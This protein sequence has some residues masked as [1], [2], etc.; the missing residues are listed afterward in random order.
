MNVKHAIA[1][2]SCTAALHL[3]NVACGVG[4]DD[5]VICPDL[6]FVASA[7]ASRYTGAKVVFAGVRS[8]EDL[9]IDPADIEAHITPRTKAVTVVHYAGFAC[10]MKEIL[11]VT[12]RYNLKVIEDCAHAPFAWESASGGSRR[13][14]GSIGDVG[15]FSFF[16]NK[17]M[18]TGEGGMVTTNDDDIAAKVKLLRS[19]GMTTLTYDR[20]RGHASRYDVVTVGYNYRLDEIRSAIG[21]CQLAKIDRLNERRREVLRWYREALADDLNIKVPFRDRDERQATPHVMPVFTTRRHEELRDLFSRRGIQVSKHYDLVT[22]F[23]AYSQEEPPRS[24]FLPYDLLSLPLGPQMTKDQV[25][26]VAVSLKSFCAE[27]AGVGM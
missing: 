12:Q 13:Y 26:E 24:F 7:N 23:S 22:S 10:R 5:E 18:T 14:V 15:C 8:L 16:S 4:S 3:A 1:V 9:T 6:T 21:I 19:H 25:D 2:N 17:N 27:A 11:D 20:D